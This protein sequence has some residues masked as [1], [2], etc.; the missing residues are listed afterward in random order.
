M[1]HPH[2]S[3][4]K[5]CLDQAIEEI[6]SNES[7]AAYSVITAIARTIRQFNLNLEVHALL[8]DAYL[9][10]KET[11]KHQEIR[12]PKAWL[13]GTAYNLARE[14]FRRRRRLHDYA[15]EL[16]DAVFADHGDGPL[17][18][19]ILQ[20][21]TAAVLQAMTRLK[22]EKPDIF[23]LIHLRVVERLAWQDIQIA[24]EQAHPGESVTEDALRKRYS[25]GRKY[26]R[27]IFHEVMPVD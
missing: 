10:G 14:E 18:G 22:T 8:F 21:E 3:P 15:P 2:D 27:S 23:E 26:L 19:A 5:D 12:V 16:I 11:L 6:L 13:K 20:A 9:R 4:P 25:R 1:P 24:Y 17:E 7:P